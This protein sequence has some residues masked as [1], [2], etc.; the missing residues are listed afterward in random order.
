MCWVNGLLWLFTL[1]G[2]TGVALASSRLACVLHDSYFVVGHF[3]YVLSMGALYG[4]LL[5]LRAYWPQLMGYS[6]NAL[7]A[8]AQFWGL[9]LG[10]NVVFMPHHWVGLAGMP[11]RY[12]DYSDTCGYLNSLSTGGYLLT[13]TSAP[14]LM[15]LGWDSVVARRCAIAPPSPNTLLDWAH[16]SPPS[17]HSTAPLPLG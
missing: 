14:L 10:V 6:P 4:I 3:H 2:L 1:G 8:T 5:A 11:R 17:P 7:L 16:H 12:P 13:L 15:A 9:F